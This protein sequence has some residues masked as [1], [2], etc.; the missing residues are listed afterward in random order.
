MDEHLLQEIGLTPGETKV[1]LALLELG[2]TTTG[3]LIKK[4][5]VSASKTYGILDKLTTKGLVGHIIKNKVKHFKA[6]HPNRLLDYIEEKEEEISQKKTLIKQLIPQLISQQQ[7]SAPTATIYNGFRSISNFF[8]NILDDLQ[9]GDTYYVLG[10]T[11]GVN[12]KG[13]R[14]F[15][16]N[17]HTNRAKKKINVKMLANY[18]TRGNLEKSVALCSSV[19]YLPKH[20]VTNMS[21]VFYKKKA[22]M[23]FLTENPFAFLIENEETV[24]NFQIYFDT[25]WKIAKK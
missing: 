6:M 7:T 5:G 18:E 25:L 21:I 8:R 4:S 14:A 17:Y 1:Y 20:F 2:M 13:V 10:A 24:K 16:L 12:A 3:P 15:F 9:K 23:F 22:F 19:R 11:Y